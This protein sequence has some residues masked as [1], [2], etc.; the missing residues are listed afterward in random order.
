[1]NNSLPAGV[2]LLP[3]WAAQE[4]VILSWPDD[5]T[6]WAPWLSDV[7]ETYRTIIDAVTGSDCLVI[8]LIRAD[9]R[10]DFEA[11]MPTNPNLLL[12]EANFDDTWVRDYGFLTCGDEQQ[13]VPVEFTF[14]GWGNKFDAHNDNQVNHQVLQ[15]LC[16]TELRTDPLVMEG[17]ALEIDQHGHLLSTA[18]C[19]G[20]PQRN[21]G[22]TNAE[23]EKRLKAALGA[24]AVTILQHG[25]LEGDDTDGHIDTLVRFTPEQGLVVQSAFN[26]PDDSHFES[27]SALVQECRERLPEHQIFELP[28]PDV[29]SDSGERL[30]ASYAN[31]LINNGQILFPVY[32]QAEDAE[33]MR[34]MQDAFPEHK[35]V[36][37]N[38]LPL[39]QQFGSIHCISMQVPC[40]TLRAEYVR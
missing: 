28:L 33:A 2:R 3:E 34:V 31:F 24:E 22:M 32:Q 15:D 21:G 25:H 29:R 16:R 17:G 18:L 13:R 7:R 6:D 20:N 23:Y 39:V 38:S 10:G 40:G 30:P 14:N 19:L 36:P 8:L 5:G 4:A 12:V 9:Q 1:M 27:L 26:R 35:I 11:S 37:I